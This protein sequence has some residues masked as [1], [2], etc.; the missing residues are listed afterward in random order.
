MGQLGR[1]HLVGQSGCLALTV[2][3][4]RWLMESSC[5]VPAPG[6]QPDDEGIGVLSLCVQ[7]LYVSGMYINSHIIRCILAGQHEANPTVPNKQEVTV[8]AN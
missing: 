6:E 8:V 4:R 2:N 3:G 7:F 1:V 5:V